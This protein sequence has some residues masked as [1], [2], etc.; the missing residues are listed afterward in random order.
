MGFLNAFSPW[1]IGSRLDSRE[2][3]NHT[4]HQTFI[5]YLSKKE[6]AKRQ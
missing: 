6:N 2:K 3:K 1:T 4:S 5:A